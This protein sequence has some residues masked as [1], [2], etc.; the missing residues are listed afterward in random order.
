MDKNIIKRDQKIRRKKR[1]RGKIT[2]KTE[3]PRLAVFKSLK[4]IYCQL[5]DDQN[6]KTIFSVSDKGLKGKKI[7]KAKQVGLLAA[8]KAAEKKIEKIVFDRSANRYHGRVAAL[9]EGAREGGL[10]F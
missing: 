9:A 1:T 5:I 6:K 4:S 8:K 2:G 7:E 3:R 10:K